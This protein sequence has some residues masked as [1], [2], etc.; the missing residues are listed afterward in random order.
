MRKVAVT[1]GIGSGKSTVCRMFSVLDI[2]VFEADREAKRS[3]AEDPGLRDAISARFGPAIYSGHDLDRQRLASIVFKD[4]QALMDL[5]ALVHPVVR[6]AFA[7]WAAASSAPYVIM[8]AAVLAETGG[9]KAFDDVVV[10]TA[11]EALRIQRVQRRDGTDAS[12]V[13]DRLRNQVS[14]E[15]RLRIADH[16][17]I[18][19]DRHLVIPQVLALH[20]LLKG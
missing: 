1:G 14:E 12:A 20:E 2:P 15:E 4:H 9:H 13:M 3:M 7:T 5:N 19:D 8:E 6:R 16:V 10:V 17:I 11:P 18:N